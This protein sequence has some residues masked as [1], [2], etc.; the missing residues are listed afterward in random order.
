[1]VE[2][3]LEG[4]GDREAYLFLLKTI[5]KHNLA[6]KSVGRGTIA[7]EEDLSSQERASTSSE[8]SRFFY[9]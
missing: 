8:R 3:P 7:D 6:H 2:D 5:H 9:S 4:L 1:M